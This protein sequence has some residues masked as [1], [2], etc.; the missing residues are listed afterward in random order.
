MIFG[1]I[2]K[3]ENAIPSAV[4]GTGYLG[5][6]HAQKYARLPQAELVAVV[7]S[8]EEHRE[9]AAKECRCL[10]VDDYR[11]LP[12]LGVRCA[13]VVTPTSTHFEV[14][15]WCLQN[16][17]DVLLEKPM[18]V[19]VSQAQQLVHLA[20]KHK[21]ILQVGHLERFNPAFRAM[22]QVLDR[23][24]FFEV[25][26]IAEFTGRGADVD[27]VLD[28]MIHDIDIVCHLVGR[29]VVRLEAIGVPVLT[30]SVDVANARIT[31]EGGA[32]ANFTASRAA[33]KSE[34]S[35]RVFQPDCYLSLDY[36]K[37]KLKIYKRAGGVDLR[38]FPSIDV[39]EIPVEE[40]DALEHEIASFL[41]A[42]ETRRV[43]EVSGADGV[44]AMELAQ[45]IRDKFKESLDAIATDLGTA[46]LK[47]GEF[48]K[49]GNA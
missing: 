43:P 20:N 41:D 49:M 48:L 2:K 19:E 42:V 16:G 10:P 46:V 7:D 24:R 22:Q 17:I 36:G 26:R 21:R 28:L 47:P 25:R 35:I 45:L 29:P 13:S 18:T 14:A 40:R 5:K 4:I 32:I 34:R 8:C 11:K 38:G 27:V 31:F 12:D 1:K 3:S 39:T 15:S 6:F 23:P 44:Q 33:F 9:R 30:G 37:K